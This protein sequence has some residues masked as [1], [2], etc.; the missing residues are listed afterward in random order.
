M[1]RE[2]RNGGRN[3]L[4][5]REGGDARNHVNSLTKL[6][7]SGSVSGQASG[8]GVDLRAHGRQAKP[9]GALDDR[10]WI[11][12]VD[13]LLR[14]DPETFEQIVLAVRLGRRFEEGTDSSNAGRDPA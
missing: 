7:E 9:L 14:L 12:L 3:G 1:R 2:D 5:Q 4:K 13:R 8:V 10:T 11:A 6:L